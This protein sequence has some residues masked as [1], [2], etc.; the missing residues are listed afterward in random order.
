M[1]VQQMP[2]AELNSLALIYFFS[3]VVFN[4]LYINTTSESA[5]ELSLC[6]L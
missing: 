5:C 2:V 6:S 1:C 3:R 4:L